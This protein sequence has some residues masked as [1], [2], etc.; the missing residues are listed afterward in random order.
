VPGATRGIRAPAASRTSG[1][2]GGLRILWADGRS[3]DREQADFAALARSEGIAA[4]DV[5]GDAIRA[6]QPGKPPHTSP[7]VE[8]LNGYDVVLFTNRHGTIPSALLGAALSELPVVAPVAG[9]VGDLIN[10]E[11]GWPVAVPNDPEAYAEALR[12]IAA[13]PAEA[14][15]RSRNLG[16]RAAGQFS[17]QAYLRALAEEPGFLG[18]RRL[19]LKRELR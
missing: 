13:A 11:T 4:L 19:T 12:Q 5:L 16:E 15:R 6:A 2:A 3:D 9:A 7:E 8:G 17:W 10:E 18:A 1:N 14:K